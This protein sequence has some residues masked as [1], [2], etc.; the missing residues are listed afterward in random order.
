MSSC[1]RRRRRKLP[2]WTKIQ[3]PQWGSERLI[4][5]EWDM[6]ECITSSTLDECHIINDDEKV[7]YDGVD[8]YRRTNGW[9]GSDLCHSFHS[10]V[11][12]SHYTISY[13]GHSNTSTGGRGG[14]GTKL[15]GLCHFTETAESHKGYCHGGSMTAVM[16]DII[17]WT[18]FCVT[19]QCIP[20]SGYT[21][22]INVTLKHPVQ[23]G[24]YLIL[25]G[26][27]VNWDGKRKVWVEATLFSNG[28]SSSSSSS[29]SSDEM[30]K[31]ENNENNCSDDEE[32][33]YCTAEGL[34]ILNNNINL[35]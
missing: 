12:I 28:S 16:D 29:G 13:D 35:V 1:E 9:R 4:M 34:V 27:I 15:T 24:S 6:D 10:S 11:R 7:A 14:V 31:V 23:I 3:I 17:G 2:P 26:T 8:K 22:Q 19:G 20:W 5:N 33:V 30:K 25:R 32:I 21:V 18:A